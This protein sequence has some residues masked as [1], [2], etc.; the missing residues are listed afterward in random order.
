MQDFK[1]QP[2]IIQVYL[3]VR[4]T[5]SHQDSDLYL[6]VC[7]EATVRIAVA[8]HKVRGLQ[9][10]ARGPNTVPEAISSGCKDISIM[11]KYDIYEKFVDLVE[12]N[13][14]QNNH[15]T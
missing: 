5:K 10:T 8:M 14:S 9:T 7:F 6:L 1:G 12:C 3:W 11:K 15:I 4:N 2:F 13:T